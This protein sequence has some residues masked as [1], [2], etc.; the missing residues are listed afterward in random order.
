MKVGYVRVSSEG[1]NTVRQLSEV[2]VDKTF[3]EKVSAKDTNR[4]ALQEM[5]GFI[6]DG[7]EVHVHSLDRLARNLQ[8]LLAV[9]NHIRAKGASLHFH[10]ESLSFKP[11][12]SDPMADLLLG[13]LGSFAQFERSLIKER[14]RE[15]I[16][17]A[18]ARGVYKGAKPKLEKDQIQALKARVASGE[19]KTVIARDYGISTQTLYTYLKSA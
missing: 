6:R 18:R 11:G 10:K 16:A 4:P 2:A 14:Q 19:K 7:D 1:Q 5:L 9:T 12:N 3:T 13:V 15:G 17:Q 8:D